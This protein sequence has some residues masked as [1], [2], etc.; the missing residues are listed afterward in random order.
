[1]RVQSYLLAGVAYLQN[2]FLELTCSIGHELG[3]GTVA[4]SIHRRSPSRRLTRLS[5]RIPGHSFDVFYKTRHGVRVSE[6]RSLWERRLGP[7]ASFGPRRKPAQRSHDR[8][9]DWIWA[10]VGKYLA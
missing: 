3:R 10:T 1:M 7:F 6:V 2:C 4:A 9:S 5:T 8:H